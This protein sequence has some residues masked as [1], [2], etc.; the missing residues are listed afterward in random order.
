MAEQYI[1]KVKIDDSDIRKLEKR[2]AALLTGKSIGGMSGGGSSGGGGSKAILGKNLAK[3]GIIATGVVG[4]LAL[5]K[6]LSSVLISSS[7]MLQ[8]VLKLLNFSIMLIFRPIGDFIGFLLRPIMVMFLRKFIIPWYTT[9]L[10][11]M[12]Q[13]GKFIGDFVSNLMGKDG[14][15]GIA[16]SLGVIGV[17]VAG[18]IAISVASAK[19]AGAVLANLVSYGGK[20][21]G[22]TFSKQAIGTTGGQNGLKATSTWAKFTDGIKNL[23]TALKFPKPTWVTKFQNVIQGFINVLK[24]P[25]PAFP[26]FGGTNM[27][28]FGQT[29]TVTPNSS[30]FKK[31]SA[32]G[33]GNQKFNQPSW[34]KE[35]LAKYGSS[36]SAKSGS[37]GKNI[38][39]TINKGGLSL[40]NLLGGSVNRV[41]SGGTAF[42]VAGMLDMVPEFKQARLDFNEFLR[43]ATG[44][45]DPSNAWKG[46]DKTGKGIG[47]PDYSQEFPFAHNVN[48][49]GSIK[50]DEQKSQSQSPT[51]VTV[52][53]GSIP[54]KS[55]AD[56]WLEQI[57]SGVYK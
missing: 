51:N 41:G 3:L 42:M 53:I 4:L 44:G 6:K 29:A 57:Q 27:G 43:D 5:T 16:V 30:S 31:T 15:E 46:L 56:Y 52:N 13:V 21:A 40:K 12:T 1:L 32:M 38:S 14:I 50:T 26:T 39:G 22:V 55:T 7:P 28:G 24:T 23:K 48:Q 47:T 34:M 33:S 2:L 49:D 37:S 45:N 35:S 20:M 9:A 19:I 17:A 54:D 8:Q 10:P 11:V 36:S 18:G 25:K